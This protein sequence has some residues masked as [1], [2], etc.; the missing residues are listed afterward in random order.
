V[1][2]LPGAVDLA[3]RNGDMVE[4][5]LDY[6][7]NPEA[8]LPFVR[9][10]LHRITRIIITMRAPEQGGAGSHSYEDRRRF[11][12][13]ARELPEVL[14]DIEFDFLNT[15]EFTIDWS[16]VICSHHDFSGVP[17]N[18]ETIYER[19]TATLARVV[20]I[21]VQASDATDCL[22]IFRLLERAQLERRELIAIAMGQA[23]IMTR[24]L[25]PSRGSFLTYASFDEESTTALGQV[26]ANDLRK[27]YRIDQID[28]ETQVFGIIGNPVAHSLSPRIHNQAFAAS[29]LN[30]VYIP[31]EVHSVEQFMRRMAHPKSRELDWRLTGLSVTAPHKSAVIGFLDWIDPAAR[32]IGAVNTIVVDGDELRGHNTDAAGFIAALR[33]KFGSL[34]GARC[35]VI[36]AGGAARAVVWALRAAGADISLFARSVE[37]ARELGQQYD[38]P[39]G[40]L[41]SANFASFNVV[42]NATPLGTRG[43]DDNETAAT[44][45]Q[46]RG[47]RLAYDLVYNPIETRFLREAR[48][49]GCETLGGLEML[50]AQAVEQFKLWTGREPDREVMR[51]AAINVLA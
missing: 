15:E 45:A 50:I 7:A 2:E 1:E 31:L 23:G 26:T 25:G 46:L 5:R 42:V 36:G 14:F 48:D 33:A 49:A 34:D 35:A 51:A 39:V 41:M 3:A 40:Q 44:A 8:A 47:V 24:I 11:W 16:R 27:L 29:D 20:K 21:A 19:M 13:L 17:S 32:E 4:L 10:L 22:A 18:L 37:Q 6:L 28:Q 38:V 9:E 43:E 12:L 30:A